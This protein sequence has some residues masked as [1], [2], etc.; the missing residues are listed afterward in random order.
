MSLILCIVI[1]TFLLSNEK[2]TVN[3]VQSILC[4]LNIKVESEES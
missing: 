2:Q 3:T 4:S 1:I